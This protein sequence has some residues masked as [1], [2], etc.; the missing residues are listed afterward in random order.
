MVLMYPS[1][2][3][4]MNSKKY[5][6]YIKGLSKPICQLQSAELIKGVNRGVLEMRAY[7]GTWGDDENLSC[8]GEPR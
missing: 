5:H 1:K 4:P 7:E 3:Y 8:S 6:G 2:E